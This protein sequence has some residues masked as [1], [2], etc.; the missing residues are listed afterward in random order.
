MEL[1]GQQTNP[2]EVDFVSFKRKIKL[3]CGL[4]LEAYKRPQMERRIRANMDKCGAKSFTDYFA[5][6]QKNNQLFDEFMDR[7]TINVSEVFRNPEQ[8]DVLKNKVL[9]ELVSKFGN[10]TIWSAGCSCGAEIYTLAILLDEV[11]P[12]RRHTILGTDID[13]RMLERA[14]S[15]I[16][17]PHEM[18]AVSKE[19]ISKYFD[20]HPDGNYQVKASLKKNISFKKHDMLRDPFPARNALVVCRNVV[21]YFTDETKKVLYSG[22][23]DSLSSGGYLFVGGTERISNYDDIGFENK[24]PFFYRK[25]LGN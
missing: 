16:Y 9:P 24:I 4:D 10:L 17:F 21:I 6:M 23:F 7:V 19:R 2:S 11:A 20:V 8:F 5:L 12:N 14:A 3:F 22:F 15:G 18:K 25:P 13:E 1:S